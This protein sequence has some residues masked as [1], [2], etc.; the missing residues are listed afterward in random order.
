MASGC[1]A[2]ADAL[3]IPFT[4][5]LAVGR[6]LAEELPPQVRLELSPTGGHVGFVH[7]TPLRPRFW[8][9]ERIPAFLD[10]HL[11]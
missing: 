2:S 10:E 9:E 3:A 7:G 11:G 5:Q 8:L 1:T 6:P 4:C